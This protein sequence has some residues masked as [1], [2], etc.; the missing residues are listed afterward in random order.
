MPFRWTV[1]PY[2]GCAMGCRYCYAAYTHEFMGIAGPSFHSLVY[3]K[4]ARE[5][6]TAR[7]LAA[8]VRTRRDASRSAPPPIPTSRRRRSAQVTRRFLEL[9]ARHR[10]VAARHHHQG[11]ARP[12]RPGPAAAASTERSR[13]VRARLARS[14]PHAELLRRLEP[15]APPPEVRIEVMRRLAEA[16]IDDVARPGPDAARRSPTTR[17]A[18][19]CCSARVAAAGVRRMFANVLF[20]RSPTRE[21]YLRWLAA[22]SRATSR[23][24]EKAYAGRVYLGGPYRERDRRELVG[25]LKRKHGFDG[26][27]AR[28]GATAAPPGAAQALQAER[29]VISGPEVRVSGVR[30]EK[31]GDGW[32]CCGSTRRAATPSTSRWWTS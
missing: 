28:R 16:G 20:L 1:N 9:V 17:R 29:L 3:V 22:S 10:G 21:K 32:P 26:D 6:E 2:R 27:D 14:R 18:S 24:T 13:A 25:R 15:W 8:V 7:R 19:T 30:I 23:P 5:A 4:R 31:T 11:R 12:A